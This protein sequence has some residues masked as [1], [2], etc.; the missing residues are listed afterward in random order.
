[1][2]ATA[3]NLGSV[4]GRQGRHQE[5]A[6][7]Q[8]EALRRFLRAFGDGHANV[9]LARSRLGGTMNALGR[10]DEA[11]R[12]LR[13]STAG[14]R[15]A[16]GSRAPD[17]AVPLTNLG[18]TLQAQGRPG[19]AE[20]VFAEAE[21]I[22]REGLGAETP[23][24]ARVLA[25]RGT[26]LVARGHPTEAANLLGDALRL[27]GRSR[28]AE[29]NRDRADAGGK[30]VPGDAGPDA[31][32]VGGVR[33]EREVRPRSPVGDPRGVDRLLR[34]VEDRDAAGGPPPNRSRASTLPVADVRS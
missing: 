2:T 25:A 3:A 16:L 5:A 1:M 31:D 29:A 26:F 18:Q 4:R 20:R 13:Q 8:A 19:E 30:R 33:L 24:L 28:R 10:P 11:E 7:F 32:V 23:D 9:A 6:Q 14:Y 22:G 15:A 21:S 34:L 12:L 17:L 27:T